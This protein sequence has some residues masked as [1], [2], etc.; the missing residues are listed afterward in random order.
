MRQDVLARNKW[1]AEA[2]NQLTIS[3]NAPDLSTY[4]ALCCMADNSVSHTPTVSLFIIESLYV[5]Y[6]SPAPLR[7]ADATFAEAADSNASLI[8]RYGRASAASPRRG[9]ERTYCDAAS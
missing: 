8:R 1:L 3:R 6:V 9:S 2:A 4:F 7:F 5:M